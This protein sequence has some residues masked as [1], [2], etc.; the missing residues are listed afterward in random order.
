MTALGSLAKV[1]R[2]AEIYEEM[3]E[4]E[5]LHISEKRRVGHVTSGG[6]ERTVGGAQSAPSNVGVRKRQRIRYG[7]EMLHCS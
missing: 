4:Q 3:R 7:N 5:R 6:W 1:S 2:G